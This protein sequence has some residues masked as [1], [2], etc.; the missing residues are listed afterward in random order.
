MS[1]MLTAQEAADELGYHL[2]HLYRLLRA[3]TIRAERFS[4]VWAIPRAEVE[5]I[6]ATQSQGGRFYPDRTKEGGTIEKE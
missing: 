1:E 6:K 3:G 4:G 5:R 2:N